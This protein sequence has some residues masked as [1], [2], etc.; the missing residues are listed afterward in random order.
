ATQRDGL[1]DEV[2][3][4]LAH[5]LAE[6]IRLTATSDFAVGVAAMNARR[7]PVFKGE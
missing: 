6:Q 2:E 1:A 4:M 5:E 7:T 3:A